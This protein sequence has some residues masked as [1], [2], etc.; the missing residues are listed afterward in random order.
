M[1][2]TDL[3]TYTFEAEEKGETVYRAVRMA[4]VWGWTNGLFLMS[5]IWK[6]NDGNSESGFEMSFLMIDFVMKDVS[7]S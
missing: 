1:Y 5:G 4:V 6:Q 7:H 2:N 3:C